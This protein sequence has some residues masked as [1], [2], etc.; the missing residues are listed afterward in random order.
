MTYSKLYDEFV[1]DVSHMRDYVRKINDLEDIL[2]ADLWEG[3]VGNLFDDLYELNLA[4]YTAL[5]EEDRKDEAVEALSN[6][7]YEFDVSDESF[8]AFAEEFLEGYLD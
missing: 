5:V 7:V 4:P 2:G 3:L 6:L 1:D 8:L